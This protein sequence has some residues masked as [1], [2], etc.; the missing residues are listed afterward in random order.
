MTRA[1]L[2]AA[3]LGRRRSEADADAAA[4]FADFISFAIG[5]DQ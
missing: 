2:S 3:D 4:G 5:Q 1:D